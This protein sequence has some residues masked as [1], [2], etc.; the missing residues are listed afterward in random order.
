MKMTI[1]FSIFCDIFTNLGRQNQFSYA[2]KRA[3]FDFLEDVDP[4]Y[5]LD[6]VAL[7]CDYVECES[8]EQARDEYT[9]LGDDA[10][11]AEVMEYLQNNTA[12]ISEDPILFATF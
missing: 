3:L 4:D 9:D 6:V 12:V 2:A 5:D 8:W 11:E 10:T 1:T 7:C